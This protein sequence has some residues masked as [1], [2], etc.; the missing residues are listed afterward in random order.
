[1]YKR[2]P[3]SLMFLRMM[4][5]APFYLLLL[6]YFLWKGRGNRH[7]SNSSPLS[8]VLISQI[9]VT[10]MAGYYVA[11]LLDLIGLQ[12]VTAQLGRMILFTYPAIVVMAI[13]LLAK[14][15][16]SLRTFLSLGLAYLGVLLI[17]GHDL[18]TFGPN[19]GLGAFYIAICAICFAFYLIASKPLIERVGSGL[20]ISIAMLFASLGIG[21]HYGLLANAGTLDTP[22]TQFS[23]RAY[24]ICLAIA[25]FCTVIPSYLTA[26]A[27]SLIGAA[28]T[29]V[30]SMAGPAFTSLA[31][32][33]ILREQFTVFHLLGILL[34][35]VGIGRLDEKA[36]P[37]NDDKVSNSVG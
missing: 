31:A 27:I 20:F 4:F 13:A 26:W 22:I 37:Q 16:P 3:V 21:I 23:I 12:Y 30:A 29:S 2:Q 17:F 1:V 28:R 7:G 19:V 6:I 24:M 5:S 18:R 25:F 33:L 35:V 32:V 11:S 15:M 9:A 36:T 8:P 34:I 10:G 14:T